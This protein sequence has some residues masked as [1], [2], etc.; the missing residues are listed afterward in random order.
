MNTMQRITEIRVGN[1]DALLCTSLVMSLLR[2]QSSTHAGE[3]HISG[4]I[5]IILTLC[6]APGCE[7]NAATFTAITNCGCQWIKVHRLNT[8]QNAGYIDAV[9]EATRIQIS[10][11]EHSY[12]SNNLKEARVGI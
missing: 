5:Q 6:T 10:E 4:I 3:T 11:A 7:G 8:G 2:S 1:P 9:R 12:S